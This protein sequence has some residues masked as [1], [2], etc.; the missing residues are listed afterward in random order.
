MAR[1]CVFAP[2]PLLTVTLEP[3]PDGSAGDA[4]IHMHAGGQGFWIAQL[5]AEM[6]VDVSM[7]ASFGGETGRVI[8]TLLAD[9]PVRLH[10]VAASGSNGAYIHDRRSGERLTMATMAPAQLS[11]HEVDE[12]YGVTFV[13][14]LEAD[15]SVLGGPGLQLPLSPDVYGRLA[16][17]ITTNDRLVIA[18]LSGDC[19]DEA[20][21][22]GASVVKVS[23]EEL[24]RDKVADDDSVSA[25]LEAMRELRKPHGAA[26][27]CTRAEAS[28][29]AWFDDRLVQ[30]EGPRVEAIDHRGAGDSLTA[31]LAAGLARGEDFPTALQFGVAAGALNAT[32][33]GLGTGSRGEIEQ[34]AGHVV[35]RDLPDG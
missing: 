24:L 19:L 21:R 12:L 11:R 20:V 9:T 26:V 34:L 35:I 29:L 1:A 28:A 22:G 4:E 25:L 14:A 17:D 31:G 16:T 32:R 5:V 27:V 8:E 2:S 7:C 6:G 30:A 33:R 3:A 13:Q 18:D 15:V 10:P 23:H